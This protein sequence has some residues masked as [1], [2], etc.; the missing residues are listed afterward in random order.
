MTEPTTRAL[1]VPGAVLTYDVREPEDTGD[2]RPL[3]IF[4]SPM[5]ASGFGQLL[6][7]FG[8]RAVITYDPRGMDRST[9]APGGEL[10]A[11][12]HAEDYHRVIEAAGLGPV[13]A[14]GSS[15]GGMCALHWVVAHPDDVSTLVSH[16]PPLVS[17]L[18]DREM[19]IKVQADIV[20]TYKR[21]GFGPAMAKFIQLVMF[22][23]PLPDDY[24]DRPAPDPAQFGLPTE[25][26]GSRDDLL[27][28]GNLAMPPFEPDAEALRGS[29]VRIVPAIGE[30]GGGSLA[31]RGGEALAALLGVTPVVFPGD[32]GGFAANEW[33]PNND[34]GT[35]AQKLREVMD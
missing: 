8:D 11:E 22:Q 16:E 33:S 2:H 17:L 6:S 23:G 34:P 35:F 27:L 4:G 3:F 9:R 15:G 24:L 30:A 29:S 13:D 1:E 28:S 7:H 20:E 19:A 31:R 14:F 32:H 5:G 10:T 12:T 26:D 18:E 21:V 25:D